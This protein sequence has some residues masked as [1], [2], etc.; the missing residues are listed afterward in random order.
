MRRR[1]ERRKGSK[2]G[3]HVKA[4]DALATWW[5]RWRAARVVAWTLYGVRPRLFE[6]RASLTARC[7]DVVRRIEAKGRPTWLN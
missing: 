3:G 4:F 2:D 1:L 5:I 7:R 6:T